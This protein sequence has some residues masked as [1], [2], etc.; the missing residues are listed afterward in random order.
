ML[1][2]VVGRSRFHLFCY[3]GAI[4][5]E[6]PAIKAWQLRLAQRPNFARSWSFPYADMDGFS[7]RAFTGSLSPLIEV[8]PIFMLPA[9]I[10]EI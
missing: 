4:F 1:S 6:R 2:D 10:Q 3:F 5:S 9:A 7:T 8:T